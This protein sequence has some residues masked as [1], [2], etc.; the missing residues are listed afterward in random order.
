MP[1]SPDADPAGE[2]VISI[3]EEADQ[4][5]LKALQSLLRDY[6][7][8]AGGESHAKALRI[9]VHNREGTLV[10]GLTGWSYWGWLHVDTLVLHESLRRSGHGSK[11]MAM[12]E[13]EARQRGCGGIY[14]ETFSF[15]ALPFYEKH[16]FSVFGEVER[17]SGEHKLYFLKK[18]LD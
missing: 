10:G 9:F 15:Q 17:F 11:L 3:E 18:R 6:N 16:G 8:A 13:A 7:N 12:A 1:P 2:Y 5:D 14:L 4:D